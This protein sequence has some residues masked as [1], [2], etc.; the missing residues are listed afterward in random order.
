MPEL[1]SIQRVRIYLSERDIVEGQPLYLAALDRLRQ[2]GAT[3][4]TAVRGVAGFGPGQRLRSAGTAGLSQSLPIVIEWVDR[5]ER[6]VRV[7]PLLDELLPNALITVEDLR[8]YRAILRAA[9]P[10]GER[11]VGEAQERDIATASPQTAAREAAELLLACGQAL[12]PVLDEQEHVVGVLAAGDLVRRGGL[13]LHPRLLDGLR[14]AEREALLA[15]LG[16][17]ALAE[18]MTAEPRTIYVEASIPQAIGMLIEWGL[19]ALPVT[20]RDGCLA[21]LFGVDQALRAALDAPS[22]TD[23]AVRAADPPVPVRLVM[24]TAVPIVA[25]DAPLAE[26]LAQ[27][28]A[29]P[30]HFMVVVA[31]GRP[32]GMLHD[33][34]VAGRLD[35]ALRA[36]WLA[37]LRVPGG[38]L[39]PAFE[40][41]TELRAGDIAAPAPTIGMAA[42]EQ[43]AIQLMLDGG[44]ERLVVVD[45]NGRLAGL[46]ARR[47]LLRSLA[48][49]STG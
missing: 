7:L 4:A 47:G 24:Q 38:M 48:Q 6:V 36:A 13:T 10:F 1:A 14:S 22:L 49:E 44:H 9:G 35:D 16:V 37:A 20:D 18:I 5:A 17:R 41:A 42:T 2:E 31:D 21:G 11:S 33:A 25:A 46:L 30:V 32:A 3:G 12:L 23:G 19:D 40:F 8:V 28:L 29:T 39:S 34:E 43:E 15:A 26:A 27:L 45:E